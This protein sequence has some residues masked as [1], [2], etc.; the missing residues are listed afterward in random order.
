MKKLSVSWSAKQLT[1]M[2]NKGTISF[3]YP[4]QRAGDQWDHWQKSDLIQSLADDYPVPPLY[5]IKEGDIYYIL[6]GK[7]RLTTIFDFI[8]NKFQLHEETEPATID[9]KEYSLAEC[10]FEELHEEV[11]DNIT[12]YML[13][14]YKLENTTDEEI[15][16]LFFKLNN[17]TPLSKQQ[18]AKSKMGTEWAKRIKKVVEHEFMTEKAAFS[19]GQI[20][21]ADNE[22][23]IL[24]TMMLL[25]KSHELKSI[26]SNHVFDYTQTFREDEQNKIALLENVIEIMDYLNDAYGEK[27][28]VLAKKVNFPMLL[29]TAKLAI[30]KDI[31]VSEFQHWTDEFKKSLKGKSDIETNYKEFGGAGSV[32]RDKTLGRIREMEKHFE[33][34]FAVCS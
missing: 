30:E 24:Q 9:G 6:D 1:K 25:D 15:E 23:A 16:K 33:E 4:I 3:D 2:F 12:D 10:Y 22:T 7:Q 18:K 17:G 29:I 28:T 32:K 5:S 13:L 34:Y 21:K 20:R 27:E 31:T 26:S 14:N 19:A 8:N 11:Q